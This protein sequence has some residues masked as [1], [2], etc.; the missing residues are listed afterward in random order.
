MRHSASMKLYQFLWRAPLWLSRTHESDYLY[1]MRTL[2]RVGSRYNTT[3]FTVQQ[4]QRH[5][6][7]QIWLTK[8]T[9]YLALK[10]ELWNVYC[11]YFGET[12][13]VVLDRTV[14]SAQK[15]LR[16]F[17]PQLSVHVCLLNS[18]PVL[19]RSSTSRQIMQH[20]DDKYITQVRHLCGWAMGCLL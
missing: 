9:L 12:Y 19:T 8:D 11:E 3:K 6:I 4:T 17:T 20:N 5:D 14:Q 18:D 10:W 13:R 2:P 15:P 16:I 1:T 7:G